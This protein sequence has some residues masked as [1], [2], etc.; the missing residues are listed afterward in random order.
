M[1]HN[2]A[3]GRARVFSLHQT[4]RR[5]SAAR[6]IICKLY[7]VPFF[8]LRSQPLVLSEATTGS[9][10]KRRILLNDVS[11][12]RNFIRDELFFSF[13]QRR[14][15][16]ATD[17]RWIGKQWS[18]TRE[19]ITYTEGRRGGGTNEVNL[20]G[21]S[22]ERRIPQQRKQRSERARIRP[23]PSIN[24]EGSLDRIED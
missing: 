1:R 23:A 5:A 24:Q 21:A 9:V 12:R 15:R 13:G 4:M 11:S 2:A 3:F 22:L 20:A 19:Q 6:F 17:C 16:E 7:R 18:V 14:I 8:F 10:D